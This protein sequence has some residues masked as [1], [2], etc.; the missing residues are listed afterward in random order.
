MP[1]SSINGIPGSWSPVISNTATTTYTFTPSIGQCALPVTQTVT[2][3]QPVTPTFSA[4][5]TNGCAPLSVNF[6]NTTPNSINCIWTLSDGTI[7]SGISTVTNVFTTDGCFDITL[8]SLGSDGC[9]SNYTES[10]IVCIEVSPVADFSMDNANLTEDDYGVNFVNTSIGAVD[11]IWDF[12]DNS[13]LNT[14]ENPYHE[15][16]FIESTY[17]IMLIAISNLGCIDTAFSSIDMLEQLL[18]FVPN[19][20]TPDGDLKNNTFQPVFTSGFDPY[21]FK[22]LIFNRWGE[23]LFETNNAAIGWDG[24]YDGIYVQDGTYTWKIEFK[25]KE[26][27]KKYFLSGH[28]NLFR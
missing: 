26:N 16:G 4:D 7:L 13:F 25:V 11:Y 3:N 1:T 28:V 12:G 5:I 23:I 15:F 10:N 27:D 21:N 9:I 14:D 19:T 17:T 2:V 20:F 22:M 8:S 24:T 6:T 18:Y